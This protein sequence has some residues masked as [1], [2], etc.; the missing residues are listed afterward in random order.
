MKRV[1]VVGSGAS[2]VHFAQT[3]LEGG[4]HVTM[5]DVGRV[6]PAAVMPDASFAALKREHADPAGYFLGQRFEGLLFPGHK[7]EYY[8][9][10]PHKGFIFEGHERFRWSAR[11]FD[12]LVSFARGGLAEAW[13]GGSFPFNADEMRDFPFEYGSFAPHYG[14]IAGRIGVNGAADDLARF[15][16]IHEHLAPG[17]ELDPHAQCLMRRYEREKARLNADLRV[18]LGRSRSAVRGDDRDGRN[19]CTQLGRCLWSC[20]REAL[21]TPSI[22][23]R[24]LL[25]HERFTYLDGLFATRFD[26]DDGQRVKRLQLVE[27]A[28]GRARTLELETL[29]LAAGTL[30]SSKLFL[31]SLRAASGRDSV[32][33]GLMDNRQV[34]VPFVNLAMLRQRYQA[35]SYQYH[36][37]ALGLE[38]DDPRH[39]VHGLVTT[40][41]TALIHPIVQSIPFDL[42][43]ALWIFRNAHAA[44]GL[45]NVNFHDERRSECQ[46]ALDGAGESSKLLVSYRPSPEEPAR[47]RAALAIVKRALSR[48]GCVVPPG[49]V[50]VRPMGASVHYAGVLPMSSERRP[51]ATS[52]DGQS[53]DVA[54]LY[55]ADGTTFPFLPAKNLTFTLMANADR[56]AQRWLEA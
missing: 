13:T 48:L 47:M 29:V 24:Q 9:F 23:L 40:L 11:G 54:G 8:G 38:R 15:I 44:L 4:A 35:D 49:M 19:G 51:L 36:Q 1:V 20:P 6:A 56:V 22:T 7:G 27:L 25:K 45:V 37:L 32:L 21:Y 5:I 30:A 18:W 31:E 41:K 52:P 3:A 53:H 16:P 17:L 33:E 12:P 43:S 28:S 46:L 55:F 2:G 50:H 34:L 10:P 42:A 39:Y 26:V 14:R